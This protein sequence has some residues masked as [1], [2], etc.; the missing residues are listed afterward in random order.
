MEKDG[1]VKIDMKGTAKSYATVAAQAKVFGDNA[2]VID[3]QF[4]DLDLNKE[5]DVVFAFQAK[6]DKKVLSY[7][8]LITGT[9]GGAQVE[10]NKA[11]NTVV[12]K[13]APLTLIATSTP[14]SSTPVS[15]GGKGTSTQP[16][17]P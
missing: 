3:P 9:E 2:M 11:L 5:G 13:T 4:S 16:K 6:I 7:E 8:K 10:N 14:A 17:K 12:E 1:N 15:P